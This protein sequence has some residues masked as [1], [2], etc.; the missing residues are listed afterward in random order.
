VKPLLLDEVKV[1]MLQEGLVG[2]TMIG[3]KN[4]SSII[5]Q[6]KPTS[7]VTTCSFSFCSLSREE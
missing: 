1:E 7:Q 5:S 3:L 4:D 6:V 2:A